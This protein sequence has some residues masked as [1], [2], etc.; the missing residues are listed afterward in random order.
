MSSIIAPMG[1]TVSHHAS[2]WRFRPAP[3]LLKAVQRCTAC[4]TNQKARSIRQTMTNHVHLVRPGAF[5][6]PKSSGPVLEIRGAG[7]VHVLGDGIGRR[8]AGI[9]THGQELRFGVLSLSRMLTRA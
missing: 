6:P 7:V 2:C 5:E 4:K 1:L 9:L 8:P 3:Q